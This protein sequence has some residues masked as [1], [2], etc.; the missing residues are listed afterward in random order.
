MSNSDFDDT[1]ML[2]V[3]DLCFAYLDAYLY[4]K[5][6]EW[7]IHG[8]IQCAILDA[9]KETAEKC[10]ADYVEQ[11]NLSENDKEEMKRNHRQWA[12]LALEGVKERLRESGKIEE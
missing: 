8:K 12:D 3:K 4:A 9:V 2:E 1:N 6:T 7:L 5:Q 10:M 11:L